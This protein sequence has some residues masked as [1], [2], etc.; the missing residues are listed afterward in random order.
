MSYSI[1]EMEA[2]ADDYESGY[3]RIPRSEGLTEPLGETGDEGAFIK[4]NIRHLTVKSPNGDVS[5]THKWEEI[6]NIILRLT[7]G[8]FIKGI[9]E[10]GKQN[11]PH[12]HFLASF[13]KK[14]SCNFLS[15]YFKKYYKLNLT[16]NLTDNPLKREDYN[17]ILH[18]Y[19]LKEIENSV[20][21]LD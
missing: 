8:K 15:N 2:I 5:Y 18:N 16:F 13:P 7:K 1:E 20:D 6:A 12:I 21:F 4:L 9:K 10:R 3:L 14:V 17:Y 19:F 11:Q